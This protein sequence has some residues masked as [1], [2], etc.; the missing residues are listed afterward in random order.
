MDHINLQAWTQPQK[1]SR[2][3]ARLVQALK[4]FPIKVKHISGKSNQRAD[5]LSRRANYDQGEGDNENV[6][7][8]PECHET[9]ARAARRERG[10]L[11]TLVRLVSNALVFREYR[12]GSLEGSATLPQRKGRK[13]CVLDEA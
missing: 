12:L 3:V 5:A 10:V 2:R 9:T 1:I 4:E 11:V 7:V 8:L 6:I 13:G